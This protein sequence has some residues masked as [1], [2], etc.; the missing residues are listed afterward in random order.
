[1]QIKDGVPYLHR[2]G[3]DPVAIQE[4]TKN[5]N[6]SFWCGVFGDEAQKG[7]TPRLAVQ[8]E[9]Y[10]SSD[11]RAFIHLLGKYVSHPQYSASGVYSKGK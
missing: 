7:N 8:V 5:R 11:L 4:R 10:G 2:Y 3:F 1:M 9:D 6:V